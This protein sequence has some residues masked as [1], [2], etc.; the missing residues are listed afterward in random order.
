MAAVEELTP[1]FFHTNSQRISSQLYICTEVVDHMYQVHDVTLDF[2][3][4]GRRCQKPARLIDV[5]IDR[6][7]VTLDFDHKDEC[8][9]K[10]LLIFIRN[11]PG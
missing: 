7:D 1:P 3:P 10:K 9:Y 8:F 2:D 5:S 4:L 6:I 11:P